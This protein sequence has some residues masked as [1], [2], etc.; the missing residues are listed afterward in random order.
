MTTAAEITT[1]TQIADT[2]TDAMLAALKSLDGFLSSQPGFLGRTISHDDAG[3]WTDYVV[4]S[5]RTAGEAASARF[6][7][8]PET[9]AVVALIEPASLSMRHETIVT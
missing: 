2:T 5:D 9:P 4:W 1:F 3:Q 6:M 8:Q 7:A